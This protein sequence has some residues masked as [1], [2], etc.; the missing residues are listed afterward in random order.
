[1]SLSNQILEIQRRFLWIIKLADIKEPWK[2]T[3]IEKCTIMRWIKLIDCFLGYWDILEGITL[4]HRRE[5]I[6]LERVYLW[7]TLAW[8]ILSQISICIKTNWI[9][10]LSRRRKPCYPWLTN[11]KESKIS[12]RTYPS[13]TIRI[14]KDFINSGTPFL[15]LLIKVIK[16]YFLEIKVLIKKIFRICMIVVRELHP[17]LI[18]IRIP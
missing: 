18:V 6:S 15:K 14:I 5:P 12:V 13:T 17:Y 8:N 4:I 11:L 7:K 2:I 3:R 16:L 1:M 10:C 9:C